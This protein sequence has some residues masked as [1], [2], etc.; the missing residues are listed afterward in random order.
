MVILRYENKLGGPFP[1]FCLEKFSRSWCR[2][3]AKI[4]MELRVAED[5]EL[6]VQGRKRS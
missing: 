5:V 6:G 3:D 1:A 4:E 2:K